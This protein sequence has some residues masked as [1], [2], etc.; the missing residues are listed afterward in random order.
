MQ[1]TQ[2]L[3]LLAT[4]E[5]EKILHYLAEYYGPEPATRR[6]ALAAHLMPANPYNP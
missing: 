1:D 3:Q 5:Q 4:D 2:G 6:P